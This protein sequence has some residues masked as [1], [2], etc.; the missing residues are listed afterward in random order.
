MNRTLSV[1]L[2]TLIVM[3]FGSYLVTFTVP[4]SETALVTT[5]GKASEKG[6]INHDGD[7]AGFYYRWPWPIQK[8][9]RF[10]RRL[11]VLE[12]RLE[13]QET[14][15]KQVIVAKVFTAWRVSDPL[16]FYRLFHGEDKAAVFLRE[17]LRTAK[18]EIG[19]FTFD[20]LTNADPD[21]IRLDEANAALLR[22][23]QE[24]LAAHDCGIE[25]R[26]VGITRIVLP[27]KITETVFSRMRQ[28]RQRLAQNA[29][30]EGKA[31]A[32][33]VVAKT[34][35]D[36]ER[37]LA[38]AD[39][40]SQRLR[41]EGDAAAAEYYREYSKDRDFALFLQKLEALK[42]TLRKNT[43]FILDTDSPPFDIL[44]E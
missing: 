13:Q 15:D 3:V 19:R 44:D 37:I 7:G 29:R 39:R 21:S 33:S 4:F 11:S 42:A 27:E 36:K 16:S 24:D 30:S 14:K 40:M 17:R 12:D 1:L 8:V 25:V 34:N 38:F 10:D 23:I 5:F 43:T 31:T 32:R 20:E 35:S 26:T 6:V 2:G 22:R 18:A 28:T 41:A 9:I